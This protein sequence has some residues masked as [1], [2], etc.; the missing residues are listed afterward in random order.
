[1]TFAQWPTSEIYNAPLRV[2]SDIRD[3]LEHGNGEREVED[4]IQELLRGDKQLWMKTIND[5][6][7]LTVITQVYDTPRK[8]VCEITYLGG[9][10][11]MG[12]IGDIKEIELW[13]REN[14][15]TDITVIGR[16]G[17]ERALR[18]KGYSPRYVT[19]GKKL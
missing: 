10:E 1:M 13:A 14:N 19:I 12:F 11:V 7:V 6:F 4:V 15:C 18:D 8:R 17:W 16:K 5:D 2:G 9:E 3:A